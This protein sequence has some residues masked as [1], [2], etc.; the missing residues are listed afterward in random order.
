[1]SAVPVVSSQPDEIHVVAPVRFDGQTRAS[2][3]VGAGGVVTSPET[4]TVV[5]AD[6]GLFPLPDGAS[7]SARAVITIR[8]TGLG[9]VDAQGRPL[10]PPS[11]SMDA[12]SA[13]VVAATLLNDSPGSYQI[14]IR[15]P[16]GASGA[17]QL[18]VTQGGLVSNA[19]PLQV[20]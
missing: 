19:I 9:A 8:A 11:A 4:L 17:R 13:E 6:P 16:P 1:G 2:A 20:N 14:Q 15:I 18:T 12:T 10:V 7:A 5:Q 3:I